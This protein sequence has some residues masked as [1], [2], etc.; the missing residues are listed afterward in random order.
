MTGTTGRTGPG[1]AEGA[2]APRL[3]GIDAVRAH[4]DRRTLTVT[5]SGP[6]PR[7]LGRDS[8]LIEGGRRV[9]GL[10]VVRVTDETGDE[11]GEGAGHRLRL[12]LDRPGDDS[13]YR[14]RMLGRG[15][16]GGRDR[17][18][19]TFRP[20]VRPEAEP[21]GEPAAA[22]TALAAPAIDYLA[23]DYASFRRLLLERLSLTLPQWTERHVPDLWITLVEILA[24]LG[25]QLS[26]HQDAV[27]TEAYL[28]T[29]R[30]RTSVRR[31]ARLVGYPMHD[32]CAARTVVCLE[33]N[34]AVTVHTED[35]AFTALPDGERPGTAGP[36]MP[37]RALATGPHPVYQPLERI[38][39]RLRPQHNSV[40]LWAWGKDAHR[41]PA[42]TTRAALL[43][44]RRDRA[45]AFRPGDLIVLEE[46]RGPDGGPP[47]PAHRQAV[48][49]TRVV[50]DTDADTGTRVLKIAWADEDALTFPLSVRNARGAD[51][52][53]DATVVARGNAVLVEHGLEN[54]WLADATAE[55][56]Q[57]P[58]SA[59]ERD[60]VRGRPFT[61]RLNGR[62]VTWSPPHPRPGD[63]AAAQ[64]HRLLDLAA[65]ARDR[66]RDLQHSATEL[67]EDDRAFLR[68]LFGRAFADET[69]PED[70]L[71]R[72]RSRFDELL[73]PKIRQLERLVRKARSGYV[74]DPSAVGWEFDLTWGGIVGASLRPDNPALHG[75]ASSA[76]R[77]DPREA[78]PAV[79]LV[80]E[81]ADR[82]GTP[83]RPPRR[84]LPAGE[85]PGAPPAPPGEESGD[86][87]KPSWLPRRD[88]LASGPRDRHVTAE[89]D[90][91]GVLSL[92]FGDGR[93]GRAPTPGSRLSAVY[94][95]GNGRAGNAGR[96]AVNRVAARGGGL[97][98]VVT[99]VRNPLPATGGTDPE[100]VAEVRIA[101]PRAPF[102]TLLRAVTAEDYATLAAQRP[103]VQRAAAALRWTGSWYEADVALD[104]D[105]TTAPSA[106]LLEDVRADLYRYR[107]IGHDVVTRPALLVPLDLALDV[108]V[109]P[110][111][112]T[113]HVRGALLRRLLPGR[114]PDG[115]TGF[116]DPSALTFG[117]PVRASVLVALCM[118]APGVRHVEV[119]RLRRIHDIDEAVPGPDVP[120]SGE[121]R[122][123][124]LEIPRL[125]GDATRPENGRLT[126]RLRGGR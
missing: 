38:E 21:A 34:T 98:G 59:P 36:V 33:T 102:R 90:D 27:A 87:A 22:P 6:L 101:A 74:L 12:T 122:M 97:D 66:L 118:G 94:R 114:R 63:L 8:F 49:L 45:L 5:F 20:A 18:E 1:D 123:R 43:D 65:Q 42:G 50:R 104:P 44:G 48:R 69:D 76:L 13:T 60:G 17:A 68:L 72:L 40:P 100:P 41:L 53:P 116:F 64:A 86:T 19:F 85:P 92:R 14:L 31:H 30:L 120:P 105:G 113:A 78:L 83:V 9:V 23:K 82:D 35:L 4:R 99:R 107:R 124:P 91:D 112:L 111:H 47:D 3:A 39:I 37:A 110:H 56:V 2:R 57:V 26:Y 51:G 25:D 16:H 46:T 67:T 93:C 125:D 11:P 115:R 89:T 106:R 95:V 77:P 58:D 126:L 73:R 119:T 10:R 24:H 117:T 88:L 7:H 80:E 70:T 32:G 108:L 62:P 61:A 29:A 55:I 109:D 75:P 15:F 81:E 28:D 103:G 52:R 71:R 121:L 54:T 79:R 96:E 84:D